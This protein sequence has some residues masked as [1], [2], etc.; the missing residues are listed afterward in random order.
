LTE[1]DKGRRLRTSGID[2]VVEAA[3][4]TDRD[5]AMT[6]GL[7]VKAPLGLETAPATISAGGKSAEVEAVEVVKLAVPK[8]TTTRKSSVSR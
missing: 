4:L 8:T 6:K 1:E 3:C 7:K 2:H 5:R